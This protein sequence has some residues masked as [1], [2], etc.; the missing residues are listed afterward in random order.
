VRLGRGKDAA[1]VTGDLIHSPLQARY[2]ELSMRADVNPTQG[3]LTRRKFLEHYCD[4]D[5]L[6]C[7]GHFPSPS[8]GHVKRWDDGFR[9]VPVD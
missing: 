7:T 3:S 5:T 6:I 9:F 2:P 1:V 8:C 4:S